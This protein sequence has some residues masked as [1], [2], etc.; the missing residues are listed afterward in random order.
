MNPIQ[1]PNDGGKSVNILGIPMLM[2]IHGRDTGGVLSVV[3]SH[4]VP[5]AARHRTS[6]TA[7]TRV[8]FQ[9]RDP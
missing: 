3:E 4:D 1:I 7:R 8:W 6:I 5:A 9:R 2:R